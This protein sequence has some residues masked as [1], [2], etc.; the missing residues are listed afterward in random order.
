[1]PTAQCE[2]IIV[3]GGPAGSTAAM[4][5]A[6]AGVRA[7]LLEKSAHPRFHI[8][9]S[10]LPRNFELLREIG[11]LAPMRRLPHVPKFGAE[12]GMGDGSRVNRFG[13]SQ[14][15]IPNAETINVERAAF[16]GMLLNEARAAGA[17]VR[18]R[19]TVRSI[20]R[21]TDGDVAVETDAGESIAGKYLIDAS[22][23][24]AVIAR[25]LGTRVPAPERHLQKVAY[26]A[27]FE[28]VERLPG[29]EAGH[30]LIAMCDEGWF[31]VIHIDERRTSIGLVIDHAVAKT[32]GVPADRM[33]AWG[34][35]RCPLI[36]QRC[37]N[38]T[39]PDTN[40]II[41]N[42]SYRCRP[43]AGPGYFLIGDAAAFIDPIFSTGVCLGMMQAREAATH[44]SGMLRGTTA[45]DAARR[46]YMRFTDGSTSVFF[47]LIRQFYDHSFRELFLNG[48]GP[49][50]M[51]RAVLGVLAGNVF[52]RPPFALRWRLALFNACVRLNRRVPLVPRQRTFSLLRAQPAFPRSTAQ[53]ATI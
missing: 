43:C 14:G 37:A 39:G 29:G 3:G 42:F 52:P 9:E 27:H 32:A 6:R 23:Q 49:L 46:R 33:L 44:L 41:A 19:V 7:V 4:L 10:L 34:M 20:G 11:L 13:F 35:A 50:D 21:L 12:F 1:M 5:L 51:H 28:G 8:G 18:E 48:T 38:A 30:P 24:S 36:R 45:P 2:V 15:F 17:D 53:L 25:H 26:F 40:Q 31:W 16:D 47:R 22:G